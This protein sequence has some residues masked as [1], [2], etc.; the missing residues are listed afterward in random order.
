MPELKMKLR[1]LGYL[2]EAKSNKVMLQ[3]FFDQ[4][5]RREET[6][7]Q[8]LVI[9]SWDSLVGSTVVTRFIYS[10]DQV[11]DGKV[12]GR[13][14]VGFNYPRCKESEVFKAISDG[15]IHEFATKPNG[16]KDLASTVIGNTALM[17]AEQKQHF[18]GLYSR[19]FHNNHYYMV[20]DEII[21]G[22]P[23]DTLCTKHNKEYSEERYGNLTADDFIQLDEDKKSFAKILEKEMKTVKLFQNLFKIKRGKPEAVDLISGDREV[24]A[25]PKLEPITPNHDGYFTFFFDRDLLNELET[26]SSV[27][28]FD[29][30]HYDFILPSLTRIPYYVGDQGEDGFLIDPKPLEEGVMDDVLGEGA[31]SAI[32]SIHKPFHTINRALTKLVVKNI[33]HPMLFK[34]AVNHVRMVAYLLS[35][36]GEVIYSFNDPEIVETFVN[37]EIEKLQAIKDTGRDIGLDLNSWECWDYTNPEEPTI[38]EEVNFGARLQDGYSDGFIN[39]VYEYCYQ[40]GH[41][42]FR[43]YTQLELVDSDGS[44]FLPKH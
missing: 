18:F 5:V 37:D 28:N 38:V 14:H 22:N 39:K 33:A 11:T 23:E 42:L 19:F 30:L 29:Y 6:N 35:Q 8:N 43:P 41:P 32:Q 21:Y 27:S 34:D 7:P 16:L 24:T 13:Y 2:T 20:N 10:F 12:E 44:E 36:R 31:D 17:D 9:H 40:S 3:R 4:V 15:T 25:E 1:T 26:S